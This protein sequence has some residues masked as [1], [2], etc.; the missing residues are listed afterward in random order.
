MA[1][2]GESITRNALHDADIL[3]TRTVTTVDAALLSGT[4]VQ[5]VGTA[6]AGMDHLDTAWLTQHGIGFANAVGANAQ[7]VTEYIA[8]CLAALHQ[9]NK[10]Q[11]KKIAGV[12]GCGHIGQR[13][14]RLLAALNFQVM[15]YDPLLTEK[16]NLNF[17]ALE[18]LL[19]TA[20]I[21]SLHTPLTTTGLFPTHHLLNEARLKT[22]KPNTILL[23]T[24]RGAVIDQAALLALNDP[25]T[26]CLDVWD[27]EPHIC[28]KLLHKVFIGT[29]HIAGYSLQAKY[30]ATQM[31]YNSVAAFFGWPAAIS[32]DDQGSSN[33][34]LPPDWIKKVLMMYNPLTHTERM[35][36]LFFTQ[37]DTA[38]LF[39]A[40]RTHYPLRQAFRA[41]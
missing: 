5:F 2:P 10:L 22:I 20:D 15:C 13:V 29:P 39:V 30:R 14:A 36:Q 31:I 21:I 8:C 32:G 26:L 12:I 7:A 18:T 3:I 28:L 1:L 24:A 6:T 41:M 17:V 11:G 9:N 35:K 19:S 23:N 25:L 38:A 37:G 33:C 16:S 40:E 4:P 27:N 34:L